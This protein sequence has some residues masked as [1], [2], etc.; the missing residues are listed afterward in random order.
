MNEPLAGKIALVTGGTRGIGRAIVNKLAEA[1][2]DVAL[3]YHN[4]HEEADKVCDSIRKLGRRAHAMQADVSDPELVSEVCE[5]VR[6]QFGKLDLLVSNAAVGVL[7]PT[8]E[9]S[10]KHWRR[11]LE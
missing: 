4:S 1:G 2:C 11:C 9:L 6:A 3:V 7:R 5:S 10:L 8:L